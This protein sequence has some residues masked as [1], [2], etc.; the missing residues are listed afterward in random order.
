MAWYSAVTDS[1]P[2]QTQAVHLMLL[3]QQDEAQAPESSDPVTRGA[4]AAALYEQ[5]G[6]PQVAAQADYTDV[7]DDSPYAQVISW[8]TEAGLMNGYGDGRFGPDD[9]LTR[10][11]L[12][13]ILWR[14]AGSPM[15][16]D[17]PGLAQ[18]SDANEI[19][20]FAQPAMAWA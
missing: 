10:E 4:L 6:K 8:V 17:Y 7:A 3:P 19:S 20:R 14:C 9:V 1:L 5:A 12:T 11:Q 18:Y 15:L 2:G 13:V 16:M